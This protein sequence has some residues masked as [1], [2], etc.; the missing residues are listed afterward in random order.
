ML[1]WITKNL[2]TIVIC[3]V[4]ICVVAIII[5]GIVKNKKKGKSSCGGGCSGCPMNGSCHQNKY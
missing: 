5:T 4:L 2:A 1:L 3:A